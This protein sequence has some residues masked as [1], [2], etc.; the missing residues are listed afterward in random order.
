M[1]DT[2]FYEQLKQ[3]GDVKLNE[4]LAKHTTFKIGGPAKFFIIVRKT[5]KLVELLNYLMAEGVD[6]LVLSGGS[7]L[8]ISDEG[9]DGLV[10]KIATNDAPKMIPKGKGFD[11]E[12]DAGVVLGMVVNLAAKNSLAGMDWAVGVPGNFGGAIR[13][14]AGAMGKDISSVTQWVDIW[15]DGEVLRIKPEDCKFAYRDTAFKH[16]KDII[17]RACIYL[18]PG[19]KQKIME[20]MQTYLKQRKHTPFPSAGSFFKNLKIDKWPGDK[21]ELPELFLQRGT[22]P[23]GWVTEQL[24]L[25]GLSSGGAKISDEH[26]N[27]VIN[28]RNATQADVLTLVEEIKQRVYNKFGVE[29]DPEVQI[30]K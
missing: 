29:L 15:R 30:I 9:Y 22:V 7:N 5:E 11:I 12:I 18:E 26:G 3:F 20:N 1:T 13:G 17:L 6:Y 8:L 16:N 4:S 24:G 27:Y 28:Y 10:I 2:S 23:V 21:K 19:D 25:R 14:N